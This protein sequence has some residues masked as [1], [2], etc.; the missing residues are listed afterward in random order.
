MAAPD[1]GNGTTVTFG[2]SSFTANI[3]GVSWGGI[4]RES[5]N[6]SHLGTTTDHTFIPGDL[7]DNGE[8]SL[9]IQYDGTVSPPIIT[10]GAAE[11]VTIDWGGV[12]VNN[13]WAASMFQTS[14]EIG[15]ATVDG[16]M[17]ATIGLKASGAVTIA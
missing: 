8:V 17:T 10:N 4:S 5:I 7:V 11:T 14:F 2:T 1:L 9:T 15:E 13:T 16:L 6:T 12:G 3:T